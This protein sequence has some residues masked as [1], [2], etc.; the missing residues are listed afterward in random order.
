MS[1]LCKMIENVLVMIHFDI[2]CDVWYC[3]WQSIILV[4]SRAY[5][6]P[7]INT[8]FYSIFKAL[9]KCIR[10]I[11]QNILNFLLFLI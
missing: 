9:H 5:K 6:A 1:I 10:L 8:K 2:F 7:N 3:N 4:N 11:K